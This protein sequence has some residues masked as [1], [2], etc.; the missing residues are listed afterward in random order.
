MSDI[1][2]TGHYM[3]I[4]IAL[5]VILLIVAAIVIGL[6]YLSYTAQ[7]ASFD[8]ENTVISE[9][10]FISQGDDIPFSN[11]PADLMFASNVEGDWDVMLLQ[12]DGTLLNLTGDDSGGQDVFASFSTDG[13][14]INFVS[15]RLDPMALGPAQVFPDGT[16]LRTLTII[17]AVLVLF[18]EAQFDWDPAWSPDG[19][20]LAW[21][22]LR[23]ANLEIYTVGLDVEVDISD[24][25]RMTNGS[26]RDWYMAWSP[27]STQLAYNSNAT[28]KENIYV[29]DV[30]TGESTQLTD[31]DETNLLHPFWSLEGD[32]LFYLRE[33]E[34]TFVDGSFGI[35]EVNPDGEDVE[36]TE[37]DIIRADPVWSPGASHI[38]FM[39]NVEGNWNIYVSR[40]DGT[41]LRRVTDGEGDYMFPVWRP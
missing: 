33:T 34:Q 25:E 37:D 22:S 41:G 39:S 1:S 38:A 23:D 9:D 18:R 28:G 2:H 16:G 27:D 8:L 14:T 24:A 32:S 3:K 19:E 13:T 5:T 40:A 11:P 30:A 31:Q 21:V 7:N 12:A 20:T 35:I 10:D 36:L 6:A 4:R 15:N 26:A 29:M 17:E